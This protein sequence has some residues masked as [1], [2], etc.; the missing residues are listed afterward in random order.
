MQLH[1]LITKQHAIHPK[2][3]SSRHVPYNQ[4]MRSMVSLLVVALIALGGYSYY[5][6]NATPAAGEGQVVTQAIS[7]TG[8]QMDLN[9]IAQAERQYFAQNGNYASLDQLA[10]TGTMNISTSGRD[11]YSY[12]VDTSST[13]FVV[14]ATHPDI[15][16]GVIQGSAAIH[17]PTVT[18]DQSMQIRQGE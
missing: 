12:N 17:Y 7:T 3:L 15:P 4:D 18:V 8:V 1:L 2:S 14:T 9:A 5:L 6:K 11:G 10:S 13:G 16:A